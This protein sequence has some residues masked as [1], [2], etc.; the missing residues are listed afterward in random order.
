MSYT[1]FIL[2]K[3]LQL[4]P[5][6]VSSTRS[7]KIAF[8]NW[9]KGTWSSDGTFF[10]F[11]K[12]SILVCSSPKWHQRRVAEPCSP[13]SKQPQRTHCFQRWCPPDADWPCSIEYCL[14]RSSAN[15]CEQLRSDRSG[16]PRC[17]VAALC[18][19][20]LPTGPRGVVLCCC[21]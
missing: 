1:L 6:T 15:E 17:T 8:R 3:K 21:H 9:S 7:A 13:L 18:T 10:R 19:R 11:E 20:M 16:G 4:S 2:L 14:R 12:C 5:R